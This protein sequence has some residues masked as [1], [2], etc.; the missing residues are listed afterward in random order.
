MSGELYQWNY[1][2]SFSGSLNT[3]AMKE[4][5]IIASGQQECVGS[6]VTLLKLNSI[7]DQTESYGGIEL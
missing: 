6:T 4:T 3:S 2:S 5:V 1:T 7:L